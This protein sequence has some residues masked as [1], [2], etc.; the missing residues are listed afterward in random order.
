MAGGGEE[1]VQA[2]WTVTDALS[3][4]FI[5]NKPTIPDVVSRANVYAQVKDILVDG[6]N[7]TTTDD[8]TVQTVS[9]AGQPGGGGLSPGYGIPTYDEPHLSNIHGTPTDG[10]AVVY[11]S[12]DDRLEFATIAGGGGISE[13]DADLRYLRLTGGTLTDA[14]TIGVTGN[15]EALVINHHGG[16]SQSALHIFTNTSGSEK[17]F[18]ASRSNQSTAFFSIEGSLGG[19]N[20]K[21]GI[22]FGGGGTAR[23]TEL[24]RD[25]ANNWKTP[26]FF[27]AQGFSITGQPLSTWN[28]LG[29]GNVLNGPPALVGAVL[30]FTELDGTATAITLPSGGGTGT[31]TYVTGI[32]TAID[33]SAPRR[34]TI[35]VTRNNGLPTLTTTHTVPNETPTGGAAGDLLAK[36][37]AAD[38]DFEF[39]DP[40]GLITPAT[41]FPS[42]NTIFE[43][44]TGITITR[45]AANNAIR[46]ASD[47]A[48]WAL[49]ANTD[50]ILP[51]KLGSGVT[52][53]DV[54]LFGDGAWKALPTPLDDIYDW[55]HQGNVDV[56]PAGKLGSGVTDHTTILY[57]DGA[58]QVPAFLTAAGVY[59]W[60][61]E[62]NVDRLPIDKMP[63]VLRTVTHFTYAA[64]SRQLGMFFTNTVGISE[65]T[66]VILPDFLVAADVAV[67]DIHDTVTT[68]A[69]IQAAD[70]FIFSDESVADDPMRYA[71]ADA[72]VPYVLGHIAESDIPG[73][74]TRDNEVESFA[75][76]AHPNAVVGYD[77]M[78]PV[79]RG[80]SALIYDS[81]TRTVRATTT[82]SSGLT[83]TTATGA[84]PIGITLADIYDWAEEGDAA[85]I[86][87]A[88]IPNLSTSK[89]QNLGEYVEDRVANN[90]VRPGNLLQWVYDDAAGT[91]TPNILTDTAGIRQVIENVI[92]EPVGGLTRVYNSGLH[93][94]TLGLDLETLIQ[95]GANMVKSYNGTTGVLTIDALG[96]G[97][98]TGI[99]AAQARI[100]AQDVV[101]VGGGIIRVEGGGQVALSLNNEVMLDTVA[102]S[103]VTSGNITVTYQDVQNQI[104]FSTDALNETEVDLRINTLAPENRL[105]GPGGANFQ[106]WVK[107]SSTDY[108]MQ[109]LSLTSNGDLNIANPTFED[110]I[111]APSR[112]A[113]ARAIAAN[114]GAGGDL[115]NYVDDITHSLVGQ[116]LTLT[117]SRSGGLID[118]FE[119]ITLP[120]AVFTDTNDYV[121]SFDADLVGQVLT[122]T[123]G[124]TGALSTIVQSVTLPSGGGGAADGVVTGGS[125]S[126][127]SLTLERSVGADV[128][129]TGL[130]SGGGGT[131]NTDPVVYLARTAADTTDGVQEIELTTALEDGY[132]LAF[133]VDSGTGDTLAGRVVIPSTL[134]RALPAKATGPAVG[135]I[136]DGYSQA[137]TRVTLTSSLSQGLSNFTVWFKDDTHVWILD[138]R[139]EIEGVAIT[140]YP[141]AGGAAGGG[142]GTD[143]NDYV[144]DFTASVSGQTLAL[145]L[146]RT[147]TLGDLTQSVTIPT[148]S[149]GFSLEQ[150]Q[151]AMVSFLNFGN[152]ITDTYD[153]VNNVYNINSADNYVNHLGATV[154]SDEL[155]IT[156]GRTGSL[157]D[158]QQTVTLPTGGGGTVSNEHIRDT[159]AAFTKAGDGISI[160]HYDRP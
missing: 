159:I 54:A 107:D 69:N 114:I 134:L 11:D 80:L 75:L 65:S 67:F 18:Q 12:T 68:P 96:G 13:A 95:V 94:L 20:S 102:A 105:I 73:T 63:S 118:L 148:G 110:Q 57:G 81:P 140:G 117:L 36:A 93:T 143:T 49:I 66:Q 85:E 126:G 48:P 15:N 44:G 147:G 160:I 1:N 70:R 91:L 150:I 61:E 139:Q 92:V 136:D 86:P 132:L 74:L 62:G 116:D 53:P 39:I 72:L 79:V 24:Y 138:S 25:S 19:G 47:T 78:A 71:R 144:D 28:A 141:M 113:T 7:I 111:R 8:D 146:G 87:A 88:K 37:T 50:V 46:I 26:D 115:N 9:I 45:D 17:A 152:N 31:D 156:L 109:W 89:I 76:L 55:A 5:L 23:D 30:T 59:D 84:I 151:D 121:D 153:D 103:L 77:K 4:A 119:V 128:V 41:V 123:V 51:G 40:S 32:I 125:V 120:S 58:F 35:Q 127:T 155:T 90:L 56:I 60:A 42:V 100:I 154:A 29:I 27:T 38:H 6:A 98:T 2:D 130:P 101:Q 14:L 135:D 157:A 104:L 108:D 82:L 142:G 99:T 21:P 131:G 83:E 112:N 122:M 97:G 43:Q 3:D 145:T 34:F 106:A 16:T 158:I 129:I 33:S 137:L 149:S 10:Q 52:S 64:A 22:A 124:R 133:D